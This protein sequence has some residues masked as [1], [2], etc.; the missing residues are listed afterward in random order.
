MNLQETSSLLLILR[1]AYPNFY[2]NMT[3]EEASATIKLWHTMFENDDFELVKFA[4]YKLIETH[5]GFPPDIA[6]VKEKLREL[7]SAVTGEPTDEELWQILKKALSNGYY[8][9][10]EEFNKLPPVV[11]RYLGSPSGLRDLALVDEKIINTVTHGQFMRQI[12]ILRERHDFERSLPEPVKNAI[13]KI[14]KR[15][16]QYDPLYSPND[17]NNSR[18]KLVDQLDRTT[19][20]EE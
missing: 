1:T 16:P 8:G 10:V 9:A 4:V 5:S 18:N 12:G 7:I 11:Q 6:G 3:K 17:F 2:R 14:L 19:K 20:T 13:Q 15:P